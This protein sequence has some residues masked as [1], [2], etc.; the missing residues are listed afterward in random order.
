MKIESLSLPKFEKKRLDKQALALVPGAGTVNTAHYE[1]SGTDYDVRV[2][3]CTGNKYDYYITDGYKE[4]RG[5]RVTSDTPLDGW[6]F[7]PAI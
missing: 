5:T 6:G 1:G 7:W 3:E 4:I 2:G